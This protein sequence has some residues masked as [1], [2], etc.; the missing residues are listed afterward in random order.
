MALPGEKCR[1]DKTVLLEFTVGC[2]Q[3][4]SGFDLPARKQFASIPGENCCRIGDGFHKLRSEA[5]QFI[6]FFCDMRPSFVREPNRDT[7]FRV[8]FI[9]IWDILCLSRQEAQL[10]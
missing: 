2:H 7:V 1:D 10:M 3:I 9:T 4:F 5:R 8:E 6:M